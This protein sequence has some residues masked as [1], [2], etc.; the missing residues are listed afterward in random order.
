MRASILP[1]FL[2][3]LGILTLLSPPARAAD[4]TVQLPAGDGFVVK[5]NTGT[6]ERLRVDEA[7]GNISR[8]G[9]L[10]LPVVLKARLWEPRAALREPVVLK[11]RASV[12]TAELNPPVV[13]NWRAATPNAEFC[14]PVVLASRATLPKA[15]LFEPAVLARRAFEPKAEFR[16]PVVLV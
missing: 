2:T 11:R 6:V 14:S 8:N 3:T 13:L 7:T 9:A 15:E 10:L 1:R 12:P 4:V 5:D 16:V